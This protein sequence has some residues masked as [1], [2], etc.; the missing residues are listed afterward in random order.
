MHGLLKELADFVS[1]EFCFRL[2]EAENDNHNR[3]FEKARHASYIRGQR[4][5]F[6]RF[7]AFNGVDCLRTFLPLDPTDSIGVSYLT[8]K[9]PLFL[10][11]KLKYLRALSFNACRIT[12]LPGSIGDLK[13]LRYLDLSRTAIKTFPESTSTLYNLQTLKLLQC[14]SLSKLLAK[15]GNLTNLR[16][17]F[18]SGSRLTEMPLQIHQLKNLQTLS[19]FMVG[20]DN[21]SGIRD[22]GQMSQLKGSLQ[23]S[24][25]QN[26][27][28]FVDAMEANV[29]EKQ[30]LDQLVF[31]WSNSFDNSFACKDEGEVQYMPQHR[32]VTMSG[33][34]ST[35]FPSFRETMNAYRQ[36]SGEL[37]L[38]GNKAMDD[39]RDETVE[40]LVLEMLQ[41]HK[42]IKEVTI[43]DYGG[44]MFPSWVESP[45]FSNIAFLKLSN[46]LKCVNVPAIGQLPSLKNLVIEGMERVKSIGA[47]FYTNGYPSVVFSIVRDFKV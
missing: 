45:L 17:L 26:V 13:H 5:L 34:R 15:M 12:E 43:K 30:D 33:Y 25:L 31:Q 1:G 46:C 14:Q 29:K 2:E 19:N 8:N 16:H 11:P 39:K 23:I 44:T 7:E 42:N 38:K 18:I 28:N 40:M 20:R 4:D 3:I 41:P 37:K 9:V 36:D 10:L 24:G 22:L 47:E 35:K 21:G 27:V 32:D 6:T